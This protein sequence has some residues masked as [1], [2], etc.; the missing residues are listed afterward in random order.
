MNTVPELRWSGL[1]RSN[2][3]KT[4]ITFDESGPCANAESISAAAAATTHTHAHAW[5][6][7]GTLAFGVFGQTFP[8]RVLRLPLEAREFRFRT[9]S[10]L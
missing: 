3:E 4:P 6:A 8:S 9:N 5:M 1:R 7:R 10:L 2:P